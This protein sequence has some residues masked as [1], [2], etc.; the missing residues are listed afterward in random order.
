VTYTRFRCH[1][2]RVIA[3]VETDAH[4][5]RRAQVVSSGSLRVRVRPGKQGV[6]VAPL[7]P[8]AGDRCTARFTVSPTKVPGKSDRRRLGMHF[9]SFAYSPR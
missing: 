6:I 8:I 4:L 5:L 2:G 7:R 3:L 9:L 1:A